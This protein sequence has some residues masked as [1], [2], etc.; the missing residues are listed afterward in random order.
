MEQPGRTFSSG[1]YR[2][3]FNGMEKDDEIK[4]SGNSLDFGARIYDSRLGRWLSRDP[5]AHLYVPISPY[6]FAL[7][8]PIYL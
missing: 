3:G 5:M 4:G 8:N 7:N 1:S 2:Y 6:V